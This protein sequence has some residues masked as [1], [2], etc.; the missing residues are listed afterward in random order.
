MSKYSDQ[1]K[2]PRWQKKRL[3][4]FERDGFK[5]RVCEHDDFTLHV[6]HLYYKKYGTPPWDYGNDALITLCEGCHE[7]EE[8]L[9]K[10]DDRIFNVLGN[11]GITRTEAL[12]IIA[13]KR[14]IDMV[15][16]LAGIL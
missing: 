14:S 5:C 7:L 10:C 15:T 12:E 11:F 4:I 6:H 9:K 13:E 8:S 3:E 1:F 16:I 2:D